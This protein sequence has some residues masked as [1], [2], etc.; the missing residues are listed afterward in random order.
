MITSLRYHS[1]S[2]LGNVVAWIAIITAN[3]EQ[4]EW[5]LRILSYGFG[6]MVSL[7]TVIHILKKWKAPAEKAGTTTTETTTSVTTQNKL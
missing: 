6:L 3:Q 5:W 1:V 7:L 2:I 4:V